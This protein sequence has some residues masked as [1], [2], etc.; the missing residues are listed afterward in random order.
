MADEGNRSSNPPITTQS[1]WE[2]AYDDYVHADI[3]ARASRED[4]QSSRDV[5]AR[6][7]RVRRI[8]MATANAVDFL[9][10]NERDISAVMAGRKKRGGS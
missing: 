7:E 5:V 6:W 3:M 4:P 8:R 1:M 9:I 2:M 10:T